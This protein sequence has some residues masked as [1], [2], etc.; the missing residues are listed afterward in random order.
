MRLVYHGLWHKHD[1]R[2]RSW[3]ISAQ[4]N[5]L[6]GWYTDCKSLEQ[7]VN[8]VGTHE[9]GDKR[10]AIDLCGLR[11]QIWRKMKE[12]IGDPLLTDFLPEDATTTLTWI[13]TS[14]MA[15]DSLTKAMKP[16][17]LKCIM[18][19]QVN[20]FTPIKEQGCETEGELRMESHGI[21]METQSFT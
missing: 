8:G 4:D 7:H 10:L 1:H 12:E 3:L 6:T 18:F 15:A 14:K 13:P 16:G 20:D 5:I 11:Q 19:G 2:D 21:G 17:V 9:V